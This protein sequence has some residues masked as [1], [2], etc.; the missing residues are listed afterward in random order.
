[1]LEARIIRPNT[2][3]YSSHV[4]LVKKR[5][6][7]WRFCVDYRALN[8]ETIPNRFFIPVID[9]LLDELH[10]TIIF[11]KL[12]LKLRYHQIGIR[13]GDEHKIAF[14]THEGL[15]VPSYAFWAIK[16]SFHISV[17]NE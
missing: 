5:D 8:K 1:M 17:C 7:G 4:L 6:G 16:C 13:T 12:D 2:T 9:E 15:R 14:R 3:M 10:G 11:I